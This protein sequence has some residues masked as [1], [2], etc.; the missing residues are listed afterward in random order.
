MGELK[1]ELLKNEL[2]YY[3]ESEKNLKNEL[4]YYIES[5]LSKWIHI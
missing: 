3:I 5:E 2:R 1:V 4:R